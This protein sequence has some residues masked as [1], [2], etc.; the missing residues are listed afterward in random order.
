M[1]K[2]FDQWLYNR[3]KHWIELGRPENFNTE[4]ETNNKI[5]NEQLNEEIDEENLENLATSSALVENED[6]ANGC[7]ICKKIGP[8]PSAILRKMWVIGWAL[9]DTPKEVVE[10]SFE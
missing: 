5:Y 8:K 6:Y 10:K 1:I 3:Y 7:Q 9:I 2:Q 4:N